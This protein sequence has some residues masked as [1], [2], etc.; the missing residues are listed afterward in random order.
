M[1]VCSRDSVR[2][3]KESPDALCWPDP[4]AAWRSA[5]SGCPAQEAHVRT[6]GPARVLSWLPPLDSTEEEAPAL[7]PPAAGQ[8]G[9]SRGERTDVKDV[10]TN[11]ALHKCQLLFWAQHPLSGTGFPWETPGASQSLG[12][13]VA[14]PWTLAPHLLPG[15]P[16]PGAVP[17]PAVHS[18][19]SPPTAVRTLGKA[20]LTLTRT[21]CD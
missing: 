8:F 19:A 9:A 13:S 11:C 1:W 10:F 18:D 17:T 7:C 14:Q 4:A 21:Q 5:S 2:A 6:P 12:G 16:P 20:R 3:L 15:P